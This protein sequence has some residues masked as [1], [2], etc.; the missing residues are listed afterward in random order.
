MYFHPDGKC[1]TFK[2]IHTA[3]GSHSQWLMYHWDSCILPVMPHGQ[4][5]RREF[6]HKVAPSPDRR[7]C[8]NSSPYRGSLGIL[9]SQGVGK[10]SGKQEVVQGSCM[11]KPSSPSPSSLLGGISLPHKWAVW[12]VSQEQVKP[13]SFE[14]LSGL[15]RS[16]KDVLQQDIFGCWPSLSYPCWTEWLNFPDTYTCLRNQ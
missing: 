2:S 9:M 13:W 14:D 10:V 16:D 6:S 8:R 4:F 3:P 11:Y 15:P 7:I 1:F 12:K 5:W